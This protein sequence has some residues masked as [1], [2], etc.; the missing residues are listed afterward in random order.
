MNKYLDAISINIVYFAVNAIFFLSVTPIA[1]NVMGV[2]FYG[3]WVMLSAF[4]LLSN[5]GNLGID[6]IVMKFSAEAPTQDY[7]QKKSNR[8]ITAGYF[9]VIVMSFVTAAFLLLAR[10]L[11]GNNIHTSMELEKRFHQ[12]ILW[13]AASI[14]PQ[15]LTRVPHGYLLSQFRNRSARQLELFSSISLW[16]GAVLI[17]HFQK[18]LVSIAVWCFF[19]NLLVFLLYF[20][21]SQRVLPFQNST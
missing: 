7:A 14:F 6:A 10:N 1:I 19:S 20:R 8:I 15:F 16:T 11:I 5:I 3:L 18:N 17:A 13:I 21:A 2:E 4:M 9:I 12:A